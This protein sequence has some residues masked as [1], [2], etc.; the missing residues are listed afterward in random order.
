MGGVFGGIR[1]KAARKCPITLLL[2]LCPYFTPA[3]RTCHAHL[4]RAPAT[5]PCH[6]HPSAPLTPLAASH[7]LDRSRSSSVKQQ[8]AGRVLACLSDTPAAP[9]ASCRVPSQ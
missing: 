8:A 9:R 3:T 2:P 7:V 5:H 1:W 6:A 4:P